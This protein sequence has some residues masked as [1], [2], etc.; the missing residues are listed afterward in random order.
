MNTEYQHQK[1]G[2]GRLCHA[3]T[4][5]FSSEHIRLLYANRDLR[6]RIYA[7]VLAN[8][9]RIADA[10]DVYQ[11]AFE[12]YLSKRLQTNK[13]EVIAPV[14]YIYGI[15][16]FKWLASLRKRRKVVMQAMVDQ[17]QHPLREDRTEAHLDAAFFLQIISDNST[18]NFREIFNLWLQ[19]YSMGEIADIHGYQSTRRVI[20]AKYRGLKRWRMRLKI[21]CPMYSLDD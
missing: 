7:F 17:D 11:D 10:E 5:A 3:R 1:V 9:G 18:P 2:Q 8:S 6:Q 12:A 19:G 16:R 21:L 4:Q 14:E 13:V 20:K 15:A